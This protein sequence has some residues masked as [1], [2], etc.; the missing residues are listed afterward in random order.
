MLK[1]WFR[2]FVRDA[3]S[4]ETQ[5]MKVYK[6]ILTLIPTLDAA[7]DLPDLLQMLRSQTIRTG[8]LVV[9][10]TSEDGTVG[11]AES[12]GCEVERIDRS[13]FNHATTRNI[14]LR[15]EADYYLFLTQDAVPV[16]DMLI[17]ALLEPFSDEEVVAAYARQMPHEDADAI[18]RFARETN[19]P[20]NSIVKSQA[21]LGTLGIKTF[22]CSNSCAIYRGDYF[23][24]VGGFTEGLI[25]N[26]DME[27]A[28]RAILAGQKVA[29]VAEAKVRHSHMYGAGDIF[30]RYF[31]IGI[32]FRTN[33]WIMQEVNRYTSTE[34][35]GV[36]QAKR[37][38]RY[39]LRHAPHALPRSVL[40]SMIKYIAFKMGRGYERLPRRMRKRLSLHKNFHA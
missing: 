1:L 16:D 24:E 21:S 11:I 26:E 10:S 5:R 19:Y 3:N 37:E 22:F 25:M 8:I 36:A 18:E 12:F 39:L 14:A 17:A 7:D 15:Y 32:F 38:L 31:D 27:Y 20:E 40:F 23:R 4:P 2:V 35:T 13:A 29:Y 30:R 28:A 34:S 6:K 33:D 9:D